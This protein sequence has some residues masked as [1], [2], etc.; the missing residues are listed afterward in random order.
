MRAFRL[1]EP[2]RVGERVQD[3][4]GGPAEAPAFQAVVVNR[5]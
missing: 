5:R 1:V 3:T 4:L 2:E